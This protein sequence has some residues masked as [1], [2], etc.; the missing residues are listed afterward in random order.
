MKKVLSILCFFVATMA[1]AQTIQVKNP[2]IW[3][4][5]PD[6]DIIRVGEYYYLV[7]TTMHMF[8]GAPIMRSTDLVHWETVSYL[9]DDLLAH[10]YLAKYILVLQK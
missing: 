6:P 3:A 9:F 7:T 4:D 1:S 8:P 2:F 5:A 10:H